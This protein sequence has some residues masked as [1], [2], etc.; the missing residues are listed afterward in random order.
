[1]VIKFESLNKKVEGCTSWKIIYNKTRLTY[2]LQIFNVYD[3]DITLYRQ[4][5]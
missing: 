5:A 4:Y 2:S 1:M 3:M